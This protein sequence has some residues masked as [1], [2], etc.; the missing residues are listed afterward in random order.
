MKCPVTFTGWHKWKEGWWNGG[1][2]HHGAIARDGKLCLN[3]FE[4]VFPETNQAFYDKLP[5]WLK[6]DPELKVPKDV[7]RI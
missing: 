4:L 2:Y 3:C 1:F 6:R 5:E 7:I